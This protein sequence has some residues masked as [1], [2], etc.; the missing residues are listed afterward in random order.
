MKY[1]HTKNVFLAF[2]VEELGPVN[3]HTHYCTYQYLCFFKLSFVYDA[4]Y[5][6]IQFGVA[7]VTF[8]LML[9]IPV[10][11]QFYLVAIDSYI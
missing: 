10:I 1:S 4:S 8:L 7:V 2:T 5:L 3:A 11:T 9:L 6:D